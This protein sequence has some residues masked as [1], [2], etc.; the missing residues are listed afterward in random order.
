MTQFVLV[1]SM[2]NGLVSMQSFH[3]LTACEQA[4]SFISSI[5]PQLTSVC[6]KDE[7]K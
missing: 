1:I 6:I 2:W 4:R 5:R 3:T 7:T